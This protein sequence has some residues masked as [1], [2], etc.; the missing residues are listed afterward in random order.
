MS[1]AEKL[2]AMGHRGGLSQG[3]SQGRLQTL[4][5][6]ILEALEIRFQTVSLFR[7]ETPAF[8]SHWIIV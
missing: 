8:F 6:N 7:I 2:K 5:D 4:Q 3:L 1:V